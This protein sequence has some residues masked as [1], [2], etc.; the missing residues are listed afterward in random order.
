MKITKNSCIRSSYGGAFD[1]EDD[2][3]FTRED[4]DELAY[5][6]C[7]KFNDWVSTQGISY[8]SKFSIADASL[9][10][11][12][13]YV[14]LSNDEGIVSSITR[15]DMRKIRRPKDIYKYEKEILHSLQIDFIEYYA[16]NSYHDNVV[17]SASEISS[18][19]ANTLYNEIHDAA[20]KVFLSPSFGFE[21]TEIDDYLHIEVD[22]NFVSD[23]TEDPLVKVEVRAEVS[24]G[25]LEKLMDALNPIVQKYDEYAYFEP[26]T[27]GIIDAYIRKSKI[28]SSIDSSEDFEDFE[29]EIKEIGQ[30][31][32]SE[33]TSINKTKVPAVFKMVN[34]EPETINIDYGGGKFD[35]A[36]DYL[37]QYDVVNLVYDPYNRS[38][39]HNKEVISLIR[40]HG[41][42][43]TA[44]CS[45]V[46]N[47][48]KEPEVRLN[49]LKNI[50]K[51]LKSNGTAYITVYEGTGK[52]DEGP[53]KSGYQLNRKTK[54]YLEEVQQVFPNATR[55]G[56][57]IIAPKSGV[58]ASVNA[59]EEWWSVHYYDE[60]PETGWYFKTKEEAEDFASGL[61]DGFEIKFLGNT[62]WHDDSQDNKDEEDWFIVKV[63][64]LGIGDT[65][66]D[67]N[68]KKFVPIE[69]DQS[70]TSAEYDEPIELP[71]TEEYFEFTI[72]QRINI[73]D[74]GKY[75]IEGFEDDYENYPDQVVTVEAELSAFNYEEVEV[76]D[77]VTISENFY[78]IFD[79]PSLNAQLPMEVGT[80]E[81]SGTLY[82]KCN[83]S[84]AVE[85]GEYVDTEN[86]SVT[87]DYGDMNIY[88]LDIEKVE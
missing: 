78:E 57:L 62:E 16:Y 84:G 54:D 28:T 44:T 53:T 31:F 11:N 67:E 17:T 59:S 45:N 68:E 10:G 9:D 60:K 49:V 13:L 87:I 82:G 47:V 1:I 76:C 18:D 71:D 37:T 26:V 27:S 88:D 52:G 40:Q 56:K 14:D 79:N 42:A 36:S 86:L 43:D 65:R 55:K 66:W 7:D 19:F 51:L 3:F 85:Y 15:I 83:I 77:A 6:I 33:N 30:E 25:G 38:S 80:Y 39:E 23:F 81:I 61:D 32:T 22:D 34:F 73:E 41:G 72:K 35:S 63:P 46:L 20:F 64:D 70:I 29:D 75:N 4:I 2:M 50:N 12:E 58:S 21:E 48:I 74:D 24:Y 8:G 69:S 5:D